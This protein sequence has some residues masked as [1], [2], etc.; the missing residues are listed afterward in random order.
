MLGQKKYAEAEPLLLSAYRGMKARERNASPQQGL[1]LRTTIERIM[2]LLHEAG[3]LQNKSALEEIRADPR[4][5][6][7][8]FDLQFPA[9]PFAP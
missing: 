4:F 5:Q 8:F 1:E 2:Q 9:D 6:D 3:Q 7:F